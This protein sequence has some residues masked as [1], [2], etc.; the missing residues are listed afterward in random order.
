[1]N[2][3]HDEMVIDA[4]EHADVVVLEAS[5][6]SSS[7]TSDVHTNASSNAASDPYVDTSDITLE[8]I[9]TRD[10][11]DE[12]DVPL[13]I[14]S[15]L[16]F[17]T[18]YVLRGEDADLTR[19][20]FTTLFLDVARSRHGSTSTLYHATNVWGE[21]F[22]LKVFDTKSADAN[23]DVNVDVD[24]GTDASDIVRDNN[25]TFEREYR[26]HRLV[27]GIKGFPSLYGAGTF[28]KHPAII[29]EW[30]EGETLDKAQ[31]RLAADGEGRLS[32]LTVARIGRDLFDILARL[33]VLSDNVVHAD[34]STANIMVDTSRLSLDEQVEEG[35]FELVIIDFG[36]S[37]IEADT[38]RAGAQANA[39]SAV[40][41][42]MHAHPHAGGA[43]TGFASP[44]ILEHM[45]A[46][47]SDEAT[48]MHAEEVGTARVSPALPNLT[49]ATDVYAAASVIYLLL[50]GDVPY[51]LKYPSGTHF[52]E[53]AEV[54]RSAPPRRRVGL[55]A[56][57]ATIAHA[58]IH[59]PEVAVT[60]NHTLHGLSGNVD[61][62][63]LKE[64]M[65]IIDDALESV[66]VACLDPQPKRRLTAADACS[67]LTLFCSRYAENVN[68]SFR[69]EELDSLRPTA[70]RKGISNLSS[71]TKR[72]I[73][74]AGKVITGALALV[75]LIYTWILTQGVGVTFSLGNADAHGTLSG[76]MVPV[77]IAVI[78]VLCHVVQSIRGTASV[79][80]A[81]TTVFLVVIG[82]LYEFF[83]LQS[84]FDPAFAKSFIFFAV[85]LNVAIPWCWSVLDLGFAVRGAKIR[86]RLGAGRVHVPFRLDSGCDHERQ[87][88]NHDNE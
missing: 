56:Q 25:D 34:L 53:L 39:Q 3:L 77:A 2:K 78:Y 29:M 24:A 50:A 47:S 26:I 70:L 65:A 13:K 49:T 83:V 38:E 5:A 40:R 18:P 11:D 36:S 69:G 66:I 68:R 55:H 76:W 1:M 35:R 44:E 10:T 16:D 87:E 67:Q 74:R 20:R 82:C 23:T 22:A 59:E 45:A 62:L 19:R 61:A 8:V 12:P 27:S 30:I 6:V 54:K 72:K 63:E 48:L 31:Q 41:A 37:F 51:G 64:A 43:S 57:A 60:V 71:R 33:D 84:A 28:E 85:L 9:C 73:N 75:S 4:Q 79:R 52:L 46:L 81:R 42:R 15:I 86:K 14:A 32:P 7:A 17:E 21:S 58:L 88:E 80:F